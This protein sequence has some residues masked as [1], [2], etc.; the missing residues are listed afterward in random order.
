MVVHI[1]SFFAASS[2]IDTSALPQPPNSG[3]NILPTV[4]KIVFGLAGSIAVLMVVINGFRYIVAQGDPNSTA[5]AKNGIIYALVGLLVVM[6]A[7]SIVAFVVHG[8][9]P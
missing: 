7:Y 3:N 5:S 9:A 4:L 2:P 6:T 8:V 1:L